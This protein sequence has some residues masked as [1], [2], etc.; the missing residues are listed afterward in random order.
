[1]RSA[2][3]Y[4]YNVLGHE[5]KD[6]IE[7]L[8]I[9]QGERELEDYLNRQDMVTMLSLEFP[10]IDEQDLRRT[11][12]RRS[13]AIYLGPESSLDLGRPNK[14][15]DHEYWEIRA[16]E[17]NVL[18]LHRVQKGFAVA[19]EGFLRT[20]G[21]FGQVS[22]LIR[23]K[24]AIDRLLDHAHLLYAFL[25]P[26]PIHTQLEELPSDINEGLTPDERLDDA[27]TDAIQR[28]W[29]TRPVFAL[30]GPPG[31]GKTTLVATL[32]KLIFDE[33]EVS[34]VL[35]TAQAHPAVDVLRAKVNAA[36]E[37]S[38]N[39][40]KPLAIRIP[41]NVEW[42]NLQSDPD[43]PVPAAKSVLE[44]ASNMLSDA[45]NGI[46][47][48]WKQR[49]DLMLPGFKNKD[50]ACGAREFVDLVERSANITYS[51]STSGALA[52]LANSPLSFDWSIIEE[53]GKAHGFDL[54]LP[55]QNAYRW[56]LIGDHQQLPPYREKD[57]EK[58]IS[59]IHNVMRLLKGL[60]DGAK[61]VDI[62][63][64]KTWFDEE[65][66]AKEQG[67]TEELAE[68]REQQKKNWKAWLRMFKS[69]YE[70]CQQISHDP[71]VHKRLTQQHRM[72][73]GSA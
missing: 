19:P 14:V 63:L 5:T 26:T 62:P 32:L 11:N 51:S 6:G 31:T 12:R 60:K 54:V 34:Q 64:I 61:I 35:V 30:Q 57:Y 53:A 33:S 55:L 70:R 28:I 9:T 36:L 18:V 42:N 41:R 1:M 7:I 71:P 59:D 58:A 73:I 69:T 39:E 17:D 20:Q 37:K 65:R 50:L 68:R 23:R 40:F 4:P 48:K 15:T 27:K 24:K 25:H 44:R 16:Y 56:L 49:I 45:N 2:E 72:C 21:M 43:Y 47:S 67:K 22:L 52:A 38:S 10:P 29:K 13:G 46:Q 66:Q 3:I 8:R